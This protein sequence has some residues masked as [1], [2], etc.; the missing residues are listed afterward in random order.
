MKG[1]IHYLTAIFIL[2]TPFHGQATIKLEKI[3]LLVN[4]EKG[5]TT[6]RV[7]N[8]GN[9]PVLLFSSVVKN[10]L[11]KQGEDPLFILSPPAARIDPGKS[12]L[13]R[14][15]LADPSGLDKTRQ[16]MRH[17]YFQEIPDMGEKSNQLK[18]N[19]RHRVVAIATPSA[20]VENKSPWQTLHWQQNGHSIQVK[21]LSPYVVRLAPTITVQPSNQ[22]FVLEQPY[23]LPGQT[24]G[25]R[26]SDRLTIP[27]PVCTSRQS[28]TRGAPYPISRSTLP[29]SSEAAFEI[30]YTATS[31]GVLSAYWLC[32][33]QSGRL[34]Y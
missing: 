29:Q 21:N 23:L 3:S 24:I 27:P 26:K 12:Q 4:Q 19:T 30:A 2:L 13:V 6:V 14:V 31:T 10:A 33:D 17:I 18:V 20:L 22:Q 1:L 9:Y 8:I 28:V 32:L 34:R 25:T 15:M 16:Q 5:E 11:S 7:D